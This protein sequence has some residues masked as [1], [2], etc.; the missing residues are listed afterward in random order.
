MA[1]YY[2]FYKWFTTNQTEAE[3]SGPDIPDPG[4]PVVGQPYPY[5]NGFEWQEQVYQSNPVQSVPSIPRHITKLAFRQRFT[6]SERIAIEIAALDNP[7]GT[8]QEREKSAA[9]R[10]YMKDVD[11]AKFI[12]LDR[13]DLQAGVNFLESIG[14]LAAGRANEIITNAITNEER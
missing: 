2:N 4:S 8:Q 11:V 6:N 14:L 3:G 10:S 7:A 1:S 9:I 13:S 5:W 12:D